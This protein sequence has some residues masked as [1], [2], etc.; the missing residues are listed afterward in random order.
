M[1]GSSELN[2]A[3]KRFLDEA[4]AATAIQSPHLVPI[5]TSGIDALNG[6]FIVYKYIS[7]GSLRDRLNDIKVLPETEV[8]NTLAPALLSA[9]QA[10]HKGSVI[11][12]DV[13]PENILYDGK[14][15]YFLADLGLVTFEGRK[16]KTRTGTFVGTPG[17]LAPERIRCESSDQEP[18]IDVYAAAVVFVE[19]LTGRKPFRASNPIEVVKEQVNKQFKPSDLIALGVPDSL[20]PLFARALSLDP[21]K[22]FKSC[23]AFLSALQSKQQSQQLKTQVTVVP[24]KERVPRS[25]YFRLLPSFVTILFGAFIF[26]YYG[27]ERETRPNAPIQRIKLAERLARWAQDIEAINDGADGQRSKLNRLRDI[28]RSF[29]K[30]VTAKS[31]VDDSIV[32]FEGK[33]LRAFHTHNL[34]LS[35]LNDDVIIESMRFL[36]DMS[37]TLRS[38]PSWNA[39]F[40][41]HLLMRYEKALVF[42]ATEAKKAIRRAVEED[43]LDE[44]LKSDFADYIQ[45]CHQKLELGPP[46]FLTKKNGQ[47]RLEEIRLEESA[48]IAKTMNMANR[49]DPRG[50]GDF[51]KQNVGEFAAVANER[52]EYCTRILNAYWRSKSSVQRDTF[53]FGTTAH[54]LRLLR[55]IVRA[56]YGATSKLLAREGFNWGPSLDS[57]NIIEEAIVLYRAIVNQS[58]ELEYNRAWILQI[59]ILEDSNVLFRNLEGTFLRKLKT[60]MQSE[61]LPSFPQNSPVRLMIE[62]NMILSELVR[63][64]GSD[65]TEDVYLRAYGP[66]TRAYEILKNEL[67]AKRGIA[68]WHQ[69]EWA[70][71]RRVLNVRRMLLVAGKKREILSHTARELEEFC[72][73][74][75]DI[76]VGTSETNHSSE[77]FL[78]NLRLSIAL[79][80]A[81]II[82]LE[83]RPLTSE[84]VNEFNQVAQNQKLFDSELEIDALHLI[85]RGLE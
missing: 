30:M 41:M 3:S 66:N 60:E 14:E 67:L 15:N 45:A 22:R 13:K 49:L 8:V 11:H 80:D 63:G 20:A 71:L 32:H 84:L 72:N 26:Y 54:H 70:F 2:E 21:K 61:V 37:R 62:A 23:K 28:H 57:T 42:K 52:Y 4:V 68:E 76:K 44:G 33:L 59:E 50:I 46:C 38:L 35:K 69:N 40:H 64:G 17:Y 9:L 56:T 53:S 5:I 83:G 12:R 58:Q 82:R 10:L 25:F 85:G 24:S 55:D 65:N 19:A 29:H 7:G 81:E 77:R 34:Q 74:I 18:T 73:R 16:A 1:G 48:K 36:Y 78:R 75:G 47:E 39:C 79:M 43:P 51:T 6:P 31:S 27:H